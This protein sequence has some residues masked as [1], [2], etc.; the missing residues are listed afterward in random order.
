VGVA[1]SVAL[2]VH[3]GASVN[4]FRCLKRL[5]PVSYYLLYNNIMF[6]VYCWRHC[7]R[8]CEHCSLRVTSN[9]FLGS[10]VGQLS[11]D[12]VGHKL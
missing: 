11:A 8:V 2:R 9:T 3:V 12:S 10:S 7:F 1:A 4:G 6:Q 5:Q